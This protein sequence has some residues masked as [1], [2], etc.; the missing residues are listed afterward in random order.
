MR[1]TSR[2]FQ[3]APQRNATLVTAALMKAVADRAIPCTRMNAD[4][5]IRLGYGRLQKR[6]KATLTS[7]TRQLAVDIASDE[8]ETNR[9]LRD[10]GLPVTMDSNL[11]HLF[12]YADLIQQALARKET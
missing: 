3:G 4:S 8:E 9:T 5:L 1:M 2:C 12:E 11:R 6:I 10:A 7:E